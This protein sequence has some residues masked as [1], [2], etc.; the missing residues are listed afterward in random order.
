[1]A[2]DAGGP[3]AGLPMYDR[4]ETRAATLRFWA[5]VREGLAARAI[6]APATLA[7]PEDGPGLWAL[8]QHPRLVLAQ[9]CGLPFRARLAGR[10]TLV[11]T[12]D[13]G[14]EGCP[15]G[16][17]RSLIVVAAADRRTRLAE[18][19]GARPAVNDAL[20]QSGWAALAAHA[21][22]AGVGLASPLLTGA[23]LASAAAVAA[24]RAGLAAIDAV[25]WAL[26]VRWEP[27]LIARLRVL[28]ATAPT[29]GLPLIAGP[30]A[31]GEATRA[32]LA[33]A[34]AALAPADR[35]AL[36][37]RAIVAIPARAY[38]ALPLPPPLPAA[39]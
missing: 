31:D 26:L 4:P 23:H 38:T 21:G 1:M 34:I 10:V 16:H 29:P 9:T 32:A 11:A 39:D 19:A 27:A 28:E 18:F 15:P 25:T 7:W 36:M 30:D 37:L 6:A 17:Y 12:P 24:G 33:D 20:S 2:P 3:V 35:A 22:A 13:H 5:L 8:W 14:V